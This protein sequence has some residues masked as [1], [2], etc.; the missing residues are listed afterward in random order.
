MTRRQARPLRHRRRLRHDRPTAP[1]SCTSRRPSARTTCASGMEN[2]LPVVNAVDAE[3]K[4]IAEVTPWAGVF[5]KDADPDITADLK[6]RGLLLGSSPTS[7][8]TRSAGAATR[9]CSTTPRPTWYV[10]TTAIKDQ[11]HRRQRRRRLAPGAHQARAL[12]QLARRQRRL[13]AQP[14]PLLGHAAA[15]LAV[16]RGPHA[17]RRLRRRAA[18]RWRPARSR[19]SGTPP[20]LRRRRRPH[21]PRVRRRD[22]PRPRGH[23][24]LVRLGLHAVRAVAL[25]V[26]ERETLRASASRPTSSARPS[27]RPAA[28]STACIA[29]A[30]LIEGR[31]S[32]KRVLCLGHILDGEGQKMSKSKGNVVRPGRH[33]RP[34]GRRRP[35]LVPVRRASSRGARGASAPRWS[36]RSCASSCSRCGTRTASSRSTPT[37]TASTRRP[38]RVAARRSGRCIDRWLVGELNTLV[39]DVTAGLEAYDATGT[40]RAI[41][42]FVDDLSNWYVRRSRRRFWKSESDADKLAAY[43]TLYEALVTVTKLLAPFTPFVAEELYQNLVR[44]STPAAPRERAPVRLAGRRRAGH[45]R[46]RVVRHGGGAARRRDGPRRAQRR[47][48]QDA[49][50][51]GRGGRGAAR[52]RGAAPSSGLRDVVLDELNVKDLRFVG[53]ED[54]LVAYV[55]QAQPQGAR[56]QAGQAARPAAGG[57]QGGGRGRARRRR[58]RRRRRRRPARRTASSVS[59]RRSSS[60]RPA[61]PRATRSRATRAASSPSRRTSTRRCARRG[62]RASSST[63]FSSRAKLPTCASRT[64]SA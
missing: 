43:H 26:R 42:Q 12:R 62:S 53:G 13:G 4:F 29:V 46:R 25:P 48:R 18:R 3:G 22:A 60:S 61:R 59:P 39:Q 33:P 36:T 31:S 56:A 27:T 28:G 30:T 52:G 49:P 55:G 24:R 41:Q 8:A 23:R 47:G 11:L 6:E 17:L 40:G 34:P 50:A 5:V 38:Q 2:D 32:Y 35:A 64:P 63:R 10:R 15:D 37:S 57:A 51:A 16:R 21:L 1:A 58:A 19:G 7:T 20:A 44:R 9:R 54:E 45:R 14:R